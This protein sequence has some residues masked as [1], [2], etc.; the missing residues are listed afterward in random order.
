M[1]RRRG[2]P[3]RT[4]RPN[5]REVPV[6]LTA[7][8]C[9]VL[10]C[11]LSA[12]LNAQQPPVAVVAP[13]NAAVTGFSG[14]LPPAQIAPGDDP[15]RLTFIDL[16]GPSLR[17]VD[18][19]HMGGPPAAQVVGAPK[20]FTFSAAA[21]GQVFGVAL[22]DSEPGNVY[23]AASSAYGLPIVAPGPDGQPSHIRAGAPGATFMRGLWGPNGGP[24]S[25]WKIDGATARVS[26]FANVTTNGRANSGAALG[27][28][29]FD[30]DSK[31]L[32][33][34][35]RETGLIH[36]FALNGADLGSY[37]HG[38]IGRAA[39]ELPPAPWKAEQT[40]DIT[41][42]QF[43]SADRAT[44]NIAAPERR[45]FGL[46]VHQRRLYYAVADSLQIWSVGLKADGSFGDDAVIEVAAPPSSGPTEISNFAFD[47]QGR[48]FLAE[49][50]APTGAFDFEALAVP[51]IGRVLR[52]TTTGQS[53][54]GRRVWQVAPDEYAIGFPRDW[55][56][57]NGG[58]AIGYNYDRA[59]DIIPESCG[60][61][62]WSTGEDLRESADAKLAQR[63]KQTGPAHVDGLQGEG[64]W[65]DR[66]RNAP[67]IES[68]FIA[69]L[70]GPPDDADRGHMGAIAIRR[71]CAPT[72]AGFMTPAAPSAIAGGPPA[73]PA[74]PGP[75]V[76]PGAPPPLKPPRTRRPPP[77]PPGNCTPDQVRR[78][79]T[80][81]CE[82]SCPRP[83]IQIGGKCCVVGE[84]APGGACSNSS[85]PAGET[86]IGP[87]NFCCNSS[88]VYTG[89]GGAPAC[90]SGPL[91]NGQC[92]PPSTSNCPPGS[93]TAGCP[94]CSGG[95]VPAGG[96][97]CLA[98]QVTST[99]ACCPADDAPGPDQKTCEP[100]FHVP[101]GPLCCA[102][103]LIPTASGACCSPANVTT[104]GVCCSGP[105]N[106][107]D[108]SEC[109]KSTENIKACAAGYTRMADGTCCNNRYVSADGRECNVG[110]RPCA[111]GET[112][113]RQGSCLPIPPPAINAP[114]CPPGAALGREGACAPIPVRACPAGET[115][116]R[117]GK[118]LP[119]APPACP[120]GETRTREGKCLPNAPSE[121]P[122][123][124]TRTRNGKCEPNAPPACP[125]GETRTRE[126]KC[127][128]T[129]PA[130][131]PPG[132]MRTRSGK[133]AL[134]AP[135]LCPPGFARNLR[136]ACAP[137]RP[138]GCP[139]GQFR[140]RFGVCVPFRGFPGS[141]PQG[142]PGGFAPRGP[143]P[144][145]E[146]PRP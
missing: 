114:A 130:E 89:A 37:D 9:A 51:A 122:H 19:Q 133:C 108:R 28:L 146:T 47:D 69:Y 142:G 78:V 144:G 136:G 54:G 49:R 63:L 90:C 4:S 50:P 121:C 70:D 103:G 29:A 34:A 113:D 65:Q 7:A 97:C 105:V 24:G 81:A 83:G 143:E 46:A 48:M 38:L 62:L 52:Y 45:I 104:A 76:P 15:D 73:P 17:I 3:S 84:L 75:P 80:G 110:S 141:F 42:G 31:S 139:A 66:P 36:R 43:D 55:R 115:R 74:A 2:N 140:T 22:D 72:R 12:D 101:V 116:T 53:A 23:V 21:I 57:A 93:S 132:E 59:G 27:G 119:N 91:V 99:G 124:E 44:W 92:L 6:W 117:D 94:V 111:P 135:A 16:N 56:N 68:Y 8:I 102:P 123:G 134:I 32:F 1:A 138:F 128:P 86:A 106:A 25:I 13:G 60:G 96:S 85:C 127:L 95:Y 10:G 40:I 18:L 5:R 64:V 88:Q 67:P 71:A 11:L 109:P 39:Q 82:P 20:P 120:P 41:S 145:G 131:C 79:S 107:A 126:S 30:P 87:S 26:L 125:H 61:F 35:D 100:I 58:V 77:P 33:V 14:A 137:A 118:C 112:R 129:A 98:S